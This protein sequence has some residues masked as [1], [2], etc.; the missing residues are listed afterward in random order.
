MILVDS[1]VWIDL[2]KGRK[3]LAV[4]RL[5][6]IRECL[7]PEIC[8]SSIIYFEVLRGISSDID[9]KKIQR[10]FDLLEIK[11]YFNKGFGN[12]VEL[13]ISVERKGFRLKKLGDWLILKTVLDHSLTL[14]TS[15][16]DFYHLQKVVSFP[17]EPER[18]I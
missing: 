17:I 14:L 8:V 16:E 6:E 12:L 11:D 13:V 7:T 18:E 4:Q 15:D 2:F 1:C 10:A 5:E 9:R 3:T